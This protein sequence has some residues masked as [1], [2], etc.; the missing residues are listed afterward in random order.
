VTVLE[1]RLRAELEGLREAGT[2]KRFNTICSPQGP[3][4]EMEGRGEVLVLSSN[5]YLG[6]AAHPD[7]VEAG[8]EGLRRYGAG[9]ASVRF[10]CGTF[11][12]HLELERELADLVGTEAALTYVSCWN[13]NEAAIPS[14]TD[15]NTVILSDELNHASII[16]AVRLAKP[17]RKAVYKHSSMDDLRAQ[18][19]S[20]EPGQRALLLTDGVFSMEG[21]L[22]KLPEIVE[23]ARGHDAVVLVD[24]SHGTG[25]LGETGRGVAEHFGLLG[26]VDVITST[27]GKALG[28]A[29][30]GFVAASE[31]VCDV[32]AQR[33]RPQLFSNAL[34]PTVACSALGAVRVLRREPGLVTKLRES[35]QVF[36]DRLRGLGFNP[37]DGEAAIVPIILGETAFAIEFSRRL[38]DRGVFVTGFGYPVVPEGTARVRVQMSAAIEPEHVERALEAFE[39][40]GRELGLI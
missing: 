32:L 15:E 11:E 34:P 1:E 29:A 12:P 38:L 5:N 20:L 22:A 8:I 33:S 9:T 28:G 14:L 27:L 36:R 7:V 24:D 2:Y 26:E 30:G 39:Q 17:A 19:D 25:V 13:A 23:L 16:D 10:I 40:V 31:E 3:V 37:L 21:D 35:T 4:V 18:L 6:L